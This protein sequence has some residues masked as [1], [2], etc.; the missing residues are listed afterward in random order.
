M[1]WMQLKKKEGEEKKKARLTIMS[2]TDKRLQE[3]PYI[4]LRV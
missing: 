3:L 2:T 1:L 4:I